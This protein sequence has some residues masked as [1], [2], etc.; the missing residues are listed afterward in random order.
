M[1]GLI[2]RVS[3]YNRLLDGQTV[4][5]RN[6][7]ILLKRIFQNEKIFVVET[8]N[9]KYNIIRICYQSIYCL[10]KCRYIFVLLSKN[11]RKFF[12][13]ILYFV[14]KIF[15]K[16]IFHILIGGSLL[17]DIKND[18]RIVKYLKSFRVN[19]VESEVL[20]NNLQKAGVTNAAF[21][22]NFKFLNKTDVIRI[23][24]NGIYRFCT[25]SRVIEEKGISVAAAAISEL[26]AEGYK[27][28]LDVY[29]LIDGRYRQQFDYILRN[30]V[31]VT[32]K[33]EV[34]PN[35]S[36]SIITQYDALLFPTMWKAEGIPG[37]I[38]DS[39][40]A[41][42]PIISSEWRYYSEM[43]EKGVTGLS[44]PFDKPELLKQTIEEYM[45]L[46][47]DKLISMRK[48]CLRRSALYTPEV[49]ECII[50]KFIGEEK[51]ETFDSLARK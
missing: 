9:Y 50:K 36:V 10:V 4:K 21:M 29:G 51:N 16:E 24:R 37:T 22:P 2:G 38:I 15:K 41:G 26:N 1:I 17:D 31:Y 32:Y 40:F 20:S 14:N 25:F 42:T 30:N 34:D 13:P 48:E 39:L 23:T 7:Y 27:C 12:F 28:T 46:K 33:G 8:E 35:K 5:T 11:G 49:V 3:K 6:I 18:K 19:W 43:L 44:Y 47:E 45:N